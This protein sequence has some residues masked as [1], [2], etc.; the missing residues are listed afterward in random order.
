MIAPVPIDALATGSP[1]SPGSV[2]S[3]VGER[4]FAA[5]S[6]LG[7]VAW[8]EANVILSE[9]E[10]RTSSGPYR[11]SITPHAG[12]ISEAFGSRTLRQVTIRK[13]DQ[14]GITA[15][16]LMRICRLVAEAPCNILYVINSL[17][18]ARRMSARL[19]AMLLACP[20]T[21]DQ[22]SEGAD[23]GDTELMTLTFQLRDMTIYFAGGGSIGAVAN[24]QISLIIVDEA[25]KIPRLTTAQNTHVVDEA[26][27]RFKSVP[28]GDALIIVFSK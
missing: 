22:L 18:E 21:R 23:H 11:V 1:W 19:R 12:P 2:L 4:V 9:K 10:S 13:N 8:N 16:V 14:S 24:K 28:S 15:H 17:E 27:S 7:Q 6:P 26:K 5:L 20:A 25:D 3:D